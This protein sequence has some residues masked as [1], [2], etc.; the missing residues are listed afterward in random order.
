MED[1]PEEI[2]KEME[3]LEKTAKEE[4]EKTK[5]VMSAKE[6]VLSP[7][8]QSAPKGVAENIKLLKDIELDV[9]IEIGKTKMFLS[10]I[11]KLGIGSVVQLDKLAGDPV[12][13][14]VNNQ[15]IAKGEIVVFDDN[16]SVRIIEFIKP[17]E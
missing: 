7:L 14:Y 2:K 13:I 6:L 1:I 10:D 12:D 8:L 17:E 11:A 9:S 15:L 3:N 4:I 5:K 16:F